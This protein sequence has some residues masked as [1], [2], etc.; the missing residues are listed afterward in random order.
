MV[1]VGMEKEKRAFEFLTKL[2]DQV[3]MC[4]PSLWYMYHDILPCLQVAVVQTC[5]A[6][7]KEQEAQAYFSSHESLLAIIRK[8]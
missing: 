7:F 6:H 5:H 1:L 3:T 2:S 8:G 4:S